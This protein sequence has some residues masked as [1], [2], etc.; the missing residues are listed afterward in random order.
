M[1]NNTTEDESYYEC[2]FEKVRLY[3]VWRE[4]NVEDAKKDRGY[5]RKEKRTR[6]ENAPKTKEELELEEMTASVFAT[7]KF[8]YEGARARAQ[9]LLE[10]KRN[11]VVKV[12]SARGSVCNSEDEGG[13]QGDTFGVSANENTFD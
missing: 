6:K 3:L 4:D 8:T 1:L 7:R 11:K 10:R 9:E 5:R 2:P 13:E 12:P